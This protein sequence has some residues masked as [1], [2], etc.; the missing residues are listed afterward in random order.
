MVKK[1]T[2]TQKRNARYPIFYALQK[3]FQNTEPATLQKQLG[4]QSA[5]KSQSAIEKFCRAQDL[6]EWLNAAH[7]DFT[8]TALSFLE[9]CKEI[10]AQGLVENAKADDF[11]NE[12]ERATLEMQRANDL[13]NSY[14]RVQTD[15]KRENQPIFAL[16]LSTGMLVIKLPIKE[17]W[18][19]RDIKTACLPEIPRI[20]RAH[21]KENGGRLGY[22]YTSNILGYTLFLKNGQNFETYHFDTQGNPTESPNPDDTQP[23]ASFG[24]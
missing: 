7:Y 8:H 16:G 19:A 5:A 13:K 23:Q 6:L 4:Y 20:V 11:Q 12:M 22:P 18:L 10:V 15:F 17:T 1:H 2:K 9:K 3:Y 14:I 21:F 24:F